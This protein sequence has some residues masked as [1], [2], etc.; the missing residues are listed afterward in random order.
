VL[1]RPITGGCDRSLKLADAWARSASGLAWDQVRD[2]VRLILAADGTL[3]AAPDVT[4]SDPA[5]PPFVSVHT[6]L[7]ADADAM[8]ILQ[9]RFSSVTT[10]GPTGVASWMRGSDRPEQSG[11]WN[12]VWTLLR[13]IPRDQLEDELKHRSI[14]VRSLDGWGDPEFCFRPGTLVRESDLEGLASAKPRWP[15]AA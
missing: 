10:R 11:D 6:A 9:Q 14:K 15:E 7:V 1:P 3:Q 2:Q 13:S 12:S 5:D 8:R 4:L